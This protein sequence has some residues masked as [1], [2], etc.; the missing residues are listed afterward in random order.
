MPAPQFAS[1]P[2][3]AAPTR[4]RTAIEHG[5]AVVNFAVERHVFA[6]A[7]KLPPGSG[8]IIYSADL[9]AGATAERVSD[10]AGQK[11]LEFLK[12]FVL[13]MVP[14]EDSLLLLTESDVP[15]DSGL[16]GSG[17]LGVAIVAAIDGA[18]GRSRSP[19]EI[20]IIGQW[21]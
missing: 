6:S 15:P 14:D 3:A 1:I 7:Q 12:A 18:Y 8:V 13:R 16:G 2:P 4:R 17:A 11:N 5:G 21:H 19:A 10:F 20:A 9:R